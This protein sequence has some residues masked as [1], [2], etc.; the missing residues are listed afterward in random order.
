MESGKAYAEFD[1]ANKQ[2]KK[3][4]FYSCLKVQK[5]FLNSHLLWPSFH[6]FEE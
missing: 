3:I 6:Y 5:K 4:E 1:A 2:F